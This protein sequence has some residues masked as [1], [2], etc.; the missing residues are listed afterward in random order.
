LDQWGNEGFF[1]IAN[2]LFEKLLNHFII[3]HNHV[4][5]NPNYLLNLS[6]IILPP[7][8]ELTFLRKD[9]CHNLK[10]ATKFPHPLDQPNDVDKPDI[11]LPSNWHG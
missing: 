8:I 9:R 11:F 3:V 1:S 5:N 10:L 4:N 2:A 7:V 6:G